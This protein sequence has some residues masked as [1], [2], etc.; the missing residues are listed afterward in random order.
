MRK[1][2][3]FTL[4]VLVLALSA[5]FTAYGADGNQDLAND[6]VTR[7]YNE[8]SADI[9]KLREAVDEELKDMHLK[10]GDIKSRMNELAIMT[11]TA[12]EDMTAWGYTPDQRDLHEQVLS[13]LSVAYSAYSSLLQGASTG[14]AA[15]GDEGKLDANALAIIVSPD[16]N[17]S[18]SLRKEITKVSKGLD[19]QVFYLQSRISKLKLDLAQAAD[20]GKKLQDAQEGGEGI[21]I[22]KTH[23]LEL[24]SAK[25]NVAL[26]RFQVRVI[27]NAFVKNVKE[28]QR[29]RRRL[30]SIQGKLIF[31]KAILDSNV[32]KLHERINEISE[33][34]NA[35]R[36]SLDSA[37]LSLIRA[38]A[39]LG[40]ADVN[41]LTNTSATYMARSARVNYWER[42]TALLEEEID[43]AR[44]AQQIWKERYKLFHNNAA[45]DEIWAVRNNAQR[46][47]QELQRQL[48]GVRTQENDLLRQIESTQEKLNTE[49]I[50]SMIQQGIIQAVENRR[51]IISEVM[52]RYESIIPAAIFLQQRLYNEANDN[53]S[54]IRIAEKVS[55]FS[56]ETIMG[57]LNTELW[58]GE[59][60]SVTVG[61]LTI[62]ILV[63]IS[64][65]F[66]ST[67]GSN[68]IK[69]RM[70][71]RVKGSVTAA[72]AVQRISFY[73]LWVA[74]A[75]IALNIVQIPLTAF[76]FMGGAIVVGLGFGMQNIFNNLI[77]G[78]IVIFSR[79]F[80][81]HDIVDVAGVQGT[82]EDIG[83]RSTTIKTWDGLDVLLPNRYFLEN[84]VTNW[85]KSDIRKREV[86]Q[87]GVSYDADSRQVE[88]L[89]LD[90][91]N[92]HSSVLKNPAPF[93]IFRNFGNDALEFEIY[94]WIELGKSS[95]LKVSSDMRHHISAVFK[96]EG[97][98]IPYPQRDIHIINDNDNDNVSKIELAKDEPAKDEKK[99]KYEKKESN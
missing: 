80:K 76:A 49:G 46:R 30:E 38:R 24:E 12:S 94:Y 7:I 41:I 35:A 8:I 22:P 45:G 34:M 69:R 5:S 1:K 77:S 98:N 85:T 58:K 19:V 9:S 14:T 13:E 87:V 42:M 37:N 83:S 23:I 63:F 64:S 54:A 55:A 90:I 66:L 95:G 36:K 47:L 97:I 91:A 56:K 68:W 92:D 18:D 44:E 52:N 4:L 59:G 60:Y 74:F 29:L 53:L 78:F 89:L 6:Y 17:M 10:P 57:F 82:V 40:S 39:H 2:F 48:E 70:L 88:K 61:K 99:E 31:P 93:V 72:N 33:E 86:L 3:L 79:P 15:G 73:V 65:F 28:I 16:I 43:F 32:D 51:K 25:V 81:V 71:K 20:L 50:S 26:S 62:A 27:W 75:L 96:R 67:W 84:N 11:S 21:E